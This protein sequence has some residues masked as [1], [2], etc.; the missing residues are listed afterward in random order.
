MYT[1]RHSSSTLAMV[2]RWRTW[3]AALGLAVLTPWV[4]A[5]TAWVLS[6]QGDAAAGTAKTEYARVSLLAHAPQG[7]APDQSVWLGV[8]IEHAPEWHTYWR[9]PGDSGLPIELNWQ[10]PAGV[11]VGDIVWP[12][13][14]KFPIG[15]LANYG[16][17]GTVLL[18]VPVTITPGFAG[19]TLDVEVHATWL[20]CRR[21]CVPE[22]ARLRMRW[23]VG[24]AIVADAA[25][26]EAALAS[27]PRPWEGRGELRVEGD[28]LHLQVAGLPADWRG[29][30]LEFF[31]ETGNLIAPGAP[32]T[33]SWEGD[34]WRAAIPLSPYRS[35][36]PDRLA[37]V[38]APPPA[39]PHGPGAT[40][41]RLTWPVSGTWPAIETPPP[42]EPTTAP[43]PAD[44]AA[45]PTPEA[46]VGLG[47]G[48]ALLGA[49]LGGVIL[50]LMPCVFPVLAI[51][52]MAF[53]SHGPHVRAQRLGGLAYTAGVVVS[54]LAL[55]A[56]LL[57]LRA[58]G[59]A[60]GWGFQLQNP[61][62][63]AALATLFTVIG[64][65]LA[66]LF[67]FGSWVPSGLAGL[68]LRHP[69]ADAFLTGVLATAIASPCTAPF[70]G[71]SL[72]L[73]V[74]LPPVQALAVFATLG[75]G[76]ALPYL[77]A[78]AWPALARRLPRPGPWM[79]TF[80]QAMAFPMFA[81]VV[82]LLWVLGQQSGIHAVAAL[83]LILLALA[84]V[85]WATRLHGRAARWLGTAAAL[86]LAA[87]LWALG[88]YVVREASAP[89]AVAAD[90]E[91]DGTWQPWSP[92]RQ[93]ELLAANR[94]VFVDFTA[95]WC[96]TC[97]VNKATVLGD[98]A[99]LHDAAAANIALL[100]ADWTRRDPVITEALSALGRSGV[101][102]YVLHVPGQAPRMLTEILSVAEV[103]AAFQAA[104]RR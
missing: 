42:T 34:V 72:G 64:L 23:P 55:G 94:P 12:T 69:A 74:T 8:R 77:A 46:S 99:V 29:Q 28:R 104:A 22:E 33:Q 75:L 91:A 56:A 52:V 2:R 49:L 17:D 51:K 95:A 89:A 79:E 48:L 92:Q 58:A 35:E 98:P 57:G 21:E 10:L 3:I 9:N 53:Q 88:P 63:V 90:A 5:Q 13:P 41:V 38:L 66:G 44:G 32:W 82:W 70:M 86:L 78:S 1:Q 83:L 71:A 96:V 93:A 73:A 7:I 54:F 40:G 45:P 87:A 39:A 76:M 24:A 67:A 6:T 26:F 85:L 19:S 43:A 100:R 20:I 47:W 103:R 84:A 61:L 16:Y 37:F 30:R 25:A 59:E 101:P 18:P 97:Q 62:V 15:E 27:A 50:N 11:Q 102:V 36:A 65:N 81:T 68:Q 14:R 4:M 80:R 60:V 31:P